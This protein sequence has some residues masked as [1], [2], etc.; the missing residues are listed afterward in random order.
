MMVDA[1]AR[2]VSFAVRVVGMRRRSAHSPLSRPVTV[3]VLALSAR[4]EMSACS[5][6]LLSDAGSVVT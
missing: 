5:L 2:I 4:P 3:I 1:V 6:V